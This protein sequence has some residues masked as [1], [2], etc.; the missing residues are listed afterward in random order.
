[1]TRASDQVAGWGSP[2]VQLVRSVTG[3]LTSRAR[4]ETYLSPCRE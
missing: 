1:M 4:Y 2:R 3:T